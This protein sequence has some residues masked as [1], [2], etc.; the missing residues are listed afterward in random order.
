MHGH[1]GEGALM[2]TFILCAQ[3]CT[4]YLYIISFFSLAM[5]A[6]SANLYFHRE[7]LI[8]TRD[9]RRVDLLTVSSY[10]GITTEEEPRLS[11]LF[12]DSDVA[13]A[14]RFT[15]KRVSTRVLVLFALVGSYA[16]L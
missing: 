3:Y 2:F 6:S 15:G 11:G 14:K 1:K 9:G 10:R 5:Q 8:M 13:R 7:P 12:P 16:Q 4:T